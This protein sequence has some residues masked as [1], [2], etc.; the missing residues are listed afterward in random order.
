MHERI[1]ISF[2]L[3]LLMPAA[4]AAAGGQ[5]RSPHLGTPISKDQ[6]AKWN[7]TVFPDGRGLPPGHGTAKEGRALYVQKCASCHGDHGQGATAEDLVSGPKL[8]TADNP[9]TAIGSYWPYATTIFDFI[10]RSM[11][12]ATPGMLS[13][14]QTYAL[15]AYLLAANKIIGENDEMNAQS[16]PKVK[17]P[18]RDGFIPIDAKK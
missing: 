9:N 12:P 8:P 17:M 14:D 3:I 7:L 13:S 5:Q 1:A 6:V 4:Y 11:P 18:N 15:T 2:A 16:L 10:R